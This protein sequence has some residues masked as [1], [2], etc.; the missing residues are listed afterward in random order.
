MDGNRAVALLLGFL[1]VLWAGTDVWA[2]GQVKSGPVQF[3]ADHYETNLSTRVTN[4]RGNVVVEIGERRLEADSV[5]LKL[6]EDLVEARGRVKVSEGS[7]SIE[8][9][10]AYVEIASSRGE[11]KNAVLRYGT[12]LYVEGRKLEALG[13]DRYRVSNGK[14]SFCQDCPQSW[15]VF[16][17]SIELEIEGY[18]E[19]HHALFQIKDQPVA[20]FPVFY[21]PIKTQR[22]SGFL[23]PEMGFQPDEL[24]FLI[25][26]PYFWAIA[27]D[28][29]T[30][31]QYTYMTL[32]GHRVSNEYRYLYSDRSYVNTKFSYVRNHSIPEVDPDRFGFSMNQRYQ[33]N[34]NWVQRYSGE[35]ASDPRYTEN[36]DADFFNNKM[37]TLTNKL[38]LAWQDDLLWAYVQGFWNTNNLMRREEFGVPSQGSLH[39]VPEFRAAA[40]SFKLLGPLRV[41]TDLEYLRLRREGLSVDP[42]TNW[43]REG[44]R[45]VLRTR[46]FLP[47]YLGDMAL[48]QTSVDFRADA[49]R[50][51]APGFEASAGRARVAVEERVSAQLFRVYQVDLGELKALKHIWEPS[52]SWGYSPNDAL[53]RHPFFGQEGAPRFDIYD[54]W[55]GD[56]SQLS[57]S[58]EEAR[59]RPHHLASWGLGTRIV[60]RFDRR[61]SR[62]Y[63]ELMGLRL[64]QDY[65]LLVQEAKRL[66]ILAF[67]AYAGW[68]V[69]SE[70]ALDVQTGEAN[71]L[72]EVSLSR[73][74][75]DLSVSQSIRTDREQ[76]RGSTRLKFLKPWSFYYA[77][78]YDARSEREDWKDRFQ[79][80]SFQLRY[81]SDASKCWFVS[82][83][84]SSRPN[85]DNPDRNRVRYHPRIGL[86]VNEA[87]VVL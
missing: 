29:D 66:N 6:L 22:Q 11:F 38:S 24:G 62:H 45:T 75:L 55:S 78:I 42:D 74:A 46:V 44:D 26:Q 80:Q 60:G 73:A 49:Y 34:R 86:V 21:F 15:S 48:S 52:V 37:P 41:H 40:P 59:L 7:T 56:I 17:T 5:D 32:G 35:L 69:R 64:S 36:F 87:G 13:E 84:V 2:Q 39:A 63:E 16:G 30:T 9:D 43:I 85:P 28:Q 18:A 57:T 83:D 53:S 47:L 67:G 51:E 12:T 68:R 27:Q 31:F 81:D 54:P 61:G 58:A 79:E 20:Y 1:L 72:N 8:G 3:S 25:G 70:I 4:A 76:Y 65:D 10:E 71:V 77:G 19:I 50:F 33:I 23:V 14:V 82:L